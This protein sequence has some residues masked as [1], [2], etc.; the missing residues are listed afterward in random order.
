MN[1]LIVPMLSGGGAS[2]GVIYSLM[3]MRNNNPIKF[4][5]DI[6]PAKHGK[7]LPVTGLCVLNPE[8]AFQRMKD[9]DNVFVMNSNY[10]S[11][12]K[13]I[14]SNRFNYIAIDN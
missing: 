6:N 13:E 8:I 14:S 4:V 10:L 9:N 5:I 11:E 12:I 1:V 3:R 7:H 2:K